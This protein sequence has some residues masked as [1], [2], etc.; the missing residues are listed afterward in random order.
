MAASTET[1]AAKRPWYRRWWM[2]L[3]VV[4]AILVAALGLLLFFL[5]FSR[6]PLPD[7]I[8]AQT[9]MVF[10]INGE[11]VSGLAADASREDRDLGELPEHVSQAVMGA[12]DRGFYDHRG[13][14]ARGIARALFTNV[15]A[16]DIEQGGSTITQQYI[17]NAEAGTEQ[18]YT[19]K[20]REAALAV[21]LEQAYDK[22]DILE[23]YI[24]T[25]YWG[26][27]AYGIEA[28][29]GAYFDATADE[30]DVNQSA[31]LAG[32]IAA[33]EAWDPVENPDRADE[34]RRF[35]LGGMLEQGWIDQAEHDELVDAG[36]PEVT[37][38]QR[39][40]MGPN[41]WYVDSVRREL[42][43]NPDID[44]NELFRGLQI[45]T[46]LDP[47][48]QELAQQTL[49]AA[50]SDG[51]TDGGAIVSV[52]PATGGVRAL[53]GGPDMTRDENNVAMR[54]PREVG[55]TFK[56]FTLQAYLEDG[57][58]PESRLSAPA[59]ITIDNDGEDYEVGNY[60]GQAYGE[61]TV[62]QAT[63][64]STN[65]VYIQMQ[66]EA[67][68]DRVVEAVASAGAP[69]SKDDEPFPT[70]TQN[71]PDDW[72]L[73]PFASLTLGSETF[74]PLE[75][76]SSFGTWAAEGVH[77]EPRLVS[78]VESQDGAVIWEADTDE[79]QDV[80]LN[81]ARTVTDALRG[82]VES[83]TGQSANIGRPAAGKTGTTQDSRDAWFVGYVP[84][85]STAVWVG[86]LDNSQIE[87]EGT[88]GGLAAPI[89]G[90]Y[91]A[92]AVE[93]W[94]VEDFVRPD[95]SQFETTG[96]EPETC[97]DGYRFAE[98]PDGVDD[99]GFYPDILTDITDEEGR[100][101]VEEKPEDE[102]DGPEEQ[103][104]DGYSFADP[105]SDDTDPMPD[106]R[107]DITDEDGRPCVEQNPQ[108]DDD[109][110][111]DDEADEGDDDGD[112][113]DD[114]NGL[115]IDD[116]AGDDDDGDDGDD[117]GGTD[118]NGAGGAG[119]DGDGDGGGDTDDGDGEVSSGGET[120]WDP[121]D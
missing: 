15:R 22:D 52:H 115:P 119:G 43:A 89:W 65:T 80:E 14:S 103:C 5:V 92:A 44:D 99:D 10:D 87:G 88:G 78:R 46:E 118:G 9:S 113:G 94:E 98:P 106:V 56:A 114:D 54:N 62:Y 74:T 53:V 112:E 25:I 45:H 69:T 16:G 7:D 111:E 116:G 13:I 63:A 67:G 120:S 30:L 71:R 121:D 93:P 75:M 97:P 91:M 37:E 38:R 36:L 40:D 90:E 100:P 28:A 49:T 104:P 107:N 4:P 27:G 11:E 101:C 85:L 84:Q 82:V 57:N 35:T 68:R 81:I 39:I 2:L 108:P 18:T 17:K 8:A 21:K 20:V 77:V 29:A 73:S 32:I 70:A 86:N 59:E 79:S 47:R 6:V 31:T 110:D 55:S 60:G 24:N 96:D 50:V 95:L 26:R 19:R 23:F 61:Q 76:A 41:A 72:T 102:D 51:P 3:L 64:S 83:G 109:A 48:L 66:E 12:E 34:R 33:P 105:P 58:S 117:G 42:A 1:A